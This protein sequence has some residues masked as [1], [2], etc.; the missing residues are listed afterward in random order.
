MQGIKVVF[1][2]VLAGLHYSSEAPGYLCTTPWKYVTGLCY[3]I[4]AAGPKLNWNMARQACEEQ[5]GDLASIADSTEQRL[6]S[7]LANGQDKQLWMGLMA[8]FDRRWQW[9]DGRAIPYVSWEPGQPSVDVNAMCGLINFE[10][11]GQWQ[12]SNC[13]EPRGYVC[14]KLDTTTPSTTTES[15]DESKNHCASGWRLHQHACFKVFNHPKTW[16]E[17]NLFCQ[18]MGGDLAS[19]Q[20]LQQN[21]FLFTHLGLKEDQ[22]N[23][24]MWI[25]LNDLRQELQFEWSDHSYVTHTSWNVEEPSNLQYRQEDC[26]VLSGQNGF[27]N[28][29]FCDL[30]YGFICKKA[31]STG[32]AEAVV[33]SGCH[34]GCEKIE[35]SCFC[36]YSRDMDFNEAKET[37]NA[38]KENLLFTL[39]SFEKLFVAS[40]LVEGRRYWSGRFNDMALRYTTTGENE[41]CTIMMMMT[42]EK[43]FLKMWSPEQC[44]SKAQVIC[45]SLVDG[46]TTNPPP[47]AAQTSEAPKSCPPKWFSAETTD[48]PTPETPRDYCFQVNAPERLLWRTWFEARKHCLAQGA[49]LASVQTPMEARLLGMNIVKSIKHITWVGLID[50]DK[51]KNWVWSDGSEFNTNLWS[52]NKPDN[53]QNSEYC[54]GL[55]PYYR[56]RLDDFD[57]ETAHPWVCGI[58]KGL[59]IKPIMELNHTSAENI[60]ENKWYLF[61]DYEYLFRLNKTEG[62]HVAQKECMQEGGNLASIHQDSERRFLW[63]KFMFTDHKA[64]WI[65]LNLDFDGH[66]CWTDQTPLDFVYWAKSEPNFFQMMET[67]VT[68]YGKNGQWNDCNCGYKKPYICKRRVGASESITHAPTLPAPGACH[69]GWSTFGNQCYRMF[70]RNDTEA[71]DW[72]TANN[73]CHSKGGYLASIQNSL[74]QAFLTT[75]LHGMESLVWVGLSDRMQEGEF[76]WAGHTST[77][78]THWGKGQPIEA[79][80]DCVALS[81][82]PM[83]AGEWSVHGC[84]IEYAFICETRKDRLAVASPTPSLLVHG[85]P[86]EDTEYKILQEKMSWWQAERACLKDGG[87]LADIP[88]GLHQA[89]LTIQAFHFGQPLW[90]GVFSNTSTEEYKL[91]YGSTLQ[92]SAWGPGEPKLASGCALLSTDGSW[93]TE[94]CSSAHNAM[95]ISTAGKSS[96]PEKDTSIGSC[97]EPLDGKKWIPWRKYCYLFELKT[98]ARWPYAVRQCLQHGGKMLS[99]HDKNE[100]SFVLKELRF[101]ENQTENVWMGL[102]ANRKGTLFWQDESPVSFTKVMKGY[103]RNNCGTFSVRDALWEWIGCRELRGYVCK[104][105]KQITSLQ[106]K[107]SSSSGSWQLP[108]GILL[109]GVLT[110]LVAGAA[111]FVVRRARGQPQNY[112]RVVFSAHGGER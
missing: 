93:K 71:L 81:T 97:P 77:V 54:G 110:A 40:L 66:F 8:T 48:F 73:L 67:C 7:A 5:G 62:F 11:F 27:W 52:Y 111:W 109:F 91:V 89:F 95:C 92:F 60:T 100:N 72:T 1:V 85:I 108:M 28:D 36:F 61:G 12:L 46:V 87:G 105:P 38:N 94:S 42:M 56:G 16:K 15:Q 41:N 99:I 74:Q 3:Q 23:V 57:C 24:S 39:N 33:T 2:L 96:N 20:N 79:S 70:G 29:T 17:A 107:S 22:R 101:S 35:K 90:I 83:R 26:V 34:Q 32:N 75:L 43:S 6:L 25:G 10:A 65:G 106:M 55:L 9:S 21:F 102:F 112:N 76:V 80:Q 104:T 19:V 53:V 30:K 78:Y 84:N 69:P 37:C 50:N 14:K 64:F 98:H 4:N 51:D 47:S 31:A 13:S 18:T 45:R 58:R 86:Y 88:N 63:K 68:I 59:S 49:E 44:S 103:S 82:N